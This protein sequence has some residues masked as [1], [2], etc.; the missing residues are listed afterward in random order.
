MRNLLLLP[1]L[2][3]ATGCGE[4]G[5]I[6]FRG[7]PVTI[8][9]SRLNDGAYAAGARVGERLGITPPAETPSAGEWR[10]RGEPAYPRRR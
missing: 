1:V 10:A 8:A 5:G 3:L 7:E 2:L 4:L 6:N 9:P